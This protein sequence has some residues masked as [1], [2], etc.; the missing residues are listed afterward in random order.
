MSTCI[1]AVVAQAQVLTEKVEEQL[2]IPLNAGLD[3]EEGLQDEDEMY[4]NLFAAA[5]AQAPAQRDKQHVP[6]QL[7]PSMIIEIEQD[8]D[9]VIEVDNPYPQIGVEV[10][11]KGTMVSKRH[12]S[13][14]NIWCL[15][16]SSCCLK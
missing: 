14:I 12:V 13:I 8:Q 2:A 4:K 16:F 9:V 11:S 5:P 10:V 3:E 15:S 6:R 1:S 7:P